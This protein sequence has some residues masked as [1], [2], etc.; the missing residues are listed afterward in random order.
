[1]QFTLITCLSNHFKIT[2]FINK[3]SI[4]VKIYII[5]NKKARRCESPSFYKDLM[6]TFF[7]ITFSNQKIVL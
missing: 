1:M 2:T 4:R 3:S 7:K 6:S 5:E